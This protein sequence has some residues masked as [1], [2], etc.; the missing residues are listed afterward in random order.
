MGVVPPLLRPSPPMFRPARALLHPLFVAAVL[1]LAVND[2]ILKGA[3]GPSLVTGKL[4]DF[5][6]L[7]VAQV[8]LATLFR[9]RTRRGFV[10]TSLVLGF[11]FAAIKTSPFASLLYERALAFVHATNVVDPTD[12]VALVVLPL[13]VRV[14]LGAM[15]GAAPPRGER[16]VLETIALLGALPFCIATSAPDHVC[17]EGSVGRPDECIEAFRGTTFVYNAGT[18]ADTV[19]I[20][21]SRAPLPSSHDP[22]RLACVLRDE[23]F[24]PPRTIAL[25]PGQAVS[26]DTIPS[27]DRAHVALVD[28]GEGFPTALFFARDPGE[29]QIPGSGWGS[30]KSN[31]A[32]ADVPVSDVRLSGGLGIDRYAKAGDVL[33]TVGATIVA[34]RCEP[35]NVEAGT[36]PE[37]GFDA[38]TADVMDAGADDDAGDG[39]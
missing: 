15:E 32:A 20:R 2:W 19:N 1:A 3:F 24:G 23:D 17:A 25:L 38:G 11:A 4:S 22:Q 7:L 16:R 14:F 21:T 13:G 35:T 27:T 29:Q 8:V 10:A 37:G 5:A 28:L 6:G 26:L 9:V 12:L 33:R 18:T 31:G 39:S 30:N 34:F 36:L